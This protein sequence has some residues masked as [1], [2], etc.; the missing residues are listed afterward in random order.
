MNEF[1]NSRPYIFFLF[2]ILNSLSGPLKA[3]YLNTDSINYKALRK[4]ITS[5][6]TA[7]YIVKTADNLA[8]SG[9]FAE[10]LELLKPFSCY[11][12][13]DT[14]ESPATISWRISTGFD[15]NYL[16][17]V[18]TAVMTREEYQ[19]YRRTL[20][21]PHALW[22]RAS[23]SYNTPLVFLNRIAPDLYI[24]KQTNRF[25]VPF[26]IF[27]EKERL[28]L[29]PSFKLE[30]RTQFHDNKGDVFE[31]FKNH[32]SD[33]AGVSLYGEI[34]S[35]SNSNSHIFWR[36]PLS[37]DW[38]HYREDLPGYE[39]TIDYRI[40][41]SIELQSQSGMI[42]ASFLTEIHYQSHYKNFDSLNLL[43]SYAS[44]EIRLRKGMLSTSFWST[45]IHEK[46]T[47]NHSI[48]S[49][50]RIESS[51][52][53]SYV[54]AQWL[55]PRIAITHMHETE[56]LNKYNGIIYGSEYSI[57]TQFTLKPL[58]NL[59]FEPGTELNLRSGGSDLYNSEAG[60]HY[61][62]LWEPQTRI[63]PFLRVRFLR[64]IF[65]LG[66][67]GAYAYENSRSDYKDSFKSRKTMRLNLDGSIYP[68][69]NFSLGLFTDYQYRSYYPYGVVGK[70]S[71]NLSFSINATI[72]IY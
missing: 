47:N 53:A 59:E 6:D 28:Q 58:N 62:F 35:T 42:S 24:S 70:R 34:T 65:D 19:Q 8:N 26:F 9:L 46:Y 67:L 38:T 1:M 10:A 64:G 56:N 31:P 3:E 44:S 40:N 68:T 33:M 20:D 51:L 54:L 41:P 36:V 43:N 22:F 27:D 48:S 18:D 29:R 21:T 5:Q 16:Q 72:R 4:H 32:P 66:L 23:A 17:D 37:I 52:N 57:S 45:W 49:I 2:F 13:N 30:K 15:Y 25:R 63:E 11:Q 60:E 61:R 69:D 39:S 14:A 12:C 71:E 55:R 7:S 50:N